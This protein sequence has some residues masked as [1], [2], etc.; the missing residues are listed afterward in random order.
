MLYKFKN[1]LIERSTVLTMAIINLTDDSFYAPSRV[2]ATW[3]D[4]DP[5]P[6]QYFCQRV[7]KA[8]KQGADIIDLGACST[9][10]GSTPVDPLTEWQ[11]LQPALE[12]MRSRYPKVPLSVDTFYPSTVARLADYGVD[13][14]NDVTGGDSDMYE[15]VAK[16]RFTYVLTHNTPLRNEAAVI[17]YFQAR[18]DRLHRA[19]V[20]DVWL[21]PGFGFGKQTQ[22]CYSMLDFV[23]ILR[24]IFDEPILAGISR[25]RMTYEPTHTT[26][27][28]SLPATIACNTIAMMQ[29]A[30]ILRVHDVEQTRQ[31]I[32]VFEAF[33]DV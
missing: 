8:L 12:I 19:G 6:E 24:Q 31:A 14:V 16:H 9:R 11:R 18:L 32:K 26:A 33:K 25:K 20:T 4:G 2:L 5:F 22:E 29:G 1:Q 28:R 23:A 21:D 15:Q 17:D 27:R 7:S 10:P 30:D 13:I 3:S